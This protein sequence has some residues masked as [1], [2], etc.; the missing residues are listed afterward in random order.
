LT[1]T[2]TDIW[3]LSFGHLGS[4]HAETALGG[5]RTQPGD[6]LLQLAREGAHIFI[7]A[8]NASRLEETARAIRNEGGRA[9]VNAFDLCKS[10]SLKAFVASAAKETGHLEILVNAAGVDH[11][12]TIADG[13]TTEWRDMFEINVLAMDVL[14]DSTLEALNARASA[15]F[16]LPGRYC[17][18]GALCGDPAS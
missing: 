15:L 14:P 17:A 6:C 5:I 16:R 2:L 18:F 7:T 13:A 9:S 1:I 12:G 10:D 8:R 11:P 4:G 3:G